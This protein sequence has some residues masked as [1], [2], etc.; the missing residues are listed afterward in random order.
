MKK[1]ILF[2]LFLLTAVSY[3]QT[4]DVSIFE[5]KHELKAGAIKLLAGPIFE[6]TYEYI[7][8]KDFTYGAS[9]LVNLSTGNDFEE[10]FSITP[11]ARFY[12]QETKEY[13]AYGF[14]VEGFAKYSTG[15]SF[16]WYSNNENYSVVSLGLSLGRKWVNSSG[17]VFE[18]LFGIG[19]TLG[20]S[21]NT[22]DA[23]VR[24]D[25]FIGYRF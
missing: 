9:L 7:N 20:N 17:F 10:D 23:I 12:F 8:S 11:F 14:F 18:P 2:S 4:K 5:R 21:N 24:F 3:S 15:E 1:I 16:D 13:G 22:P 25:L 6:G 19:R